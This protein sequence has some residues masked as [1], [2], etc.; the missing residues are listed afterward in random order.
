MNAAPSAPSSFVAIDPAR[1]YDGR[2]DSYAQSG[3]LTPNNFKTI[4]VKDGHDLEGNLTTADV[5]PVGATSIT[6]NITVT[7]ATGPNFVAVTPGDATEFTTSAINYTGVDLANA[8]SVR[9]DANRRI[10]LW[11]GN[12]TGSTFVIID[13][14]GYTLPGGAGDKGDPGEKG[15]KGDPGDKGDQGDPGPTTVAFTN[16][17]AGNTIVDVDAAADAG[18]AQTVLSTT[19]TTAAGQRLLIDYTA[20]VVCQDS[21]SVDNTCQVAVEVDGILITIGGESG[22]VLDRTHATGQFQSSGMQAV[23]GE[24]SAGVHT[25]TIGAFTPGN[26]PAEY[27]DNFQLQA[28]VLSVIPFTPAP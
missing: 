27:A 8:G 26:I 22:F 2:I 1:A 24:L 28:Q 18:T 12:N 13:I 11:G 23:S 6:Y 9:I 7:G 21:S 20:A 10:T 16:G 14:T 3:P 15:D 4:S 19:V 5:V 17:P 25:V